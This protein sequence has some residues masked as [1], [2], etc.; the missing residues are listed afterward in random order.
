MSQFAP[1]ESATVILAR[2][3]S[4]GLE[5]YMVRR[6]RASD[7]GGGAYVFPGGVLDA[8]DAAPG[9]LA[10]C[11]GVDVEEA[12]ERLRLPVE[13]AIAHWSCAVRETFEEAGVLLAQG[14]VSASALAAARGRLLDGA[15]SWET[16]LAEFGVTLDL[17][18]LG[19]FAHWITPEQ[20][21]KRFTTRFFVAE[22]PVDQSPAVDAREVDFG[23]WLSPAD[24]LARHQAGE[25]PMIFPTVRT[26]EELLA[27]DSPAALLASCRARRVEPRMPRMVR[28]DGETR[29][30]LPG[31]AGYDEAA[32]ADAGPR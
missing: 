32:T 23:E 31:D 24:A 30:L 29:I 27:F 15:L 26:L 17:A 4:A 18:R 9:V 3:A 8:A 6:H 19:Y 22:T 13:R 28:V 7:F 5:V 11:G 1:R 21:P 2:P 16:F 10:R 14:H 12:A 20:A 25:L